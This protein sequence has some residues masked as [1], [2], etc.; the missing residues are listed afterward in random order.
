MSYCKTHQRKFDPSEG[1]ALC[2]EDAEMTGTTLDESAYCDGCAQHLAECVCLDPATV[3]AATP[4]ADEILVETFGPIL[5]K[6]T[7]AGLFPRHPDCKNHLSSEEPGCDWC[8]NQF[9]LDGMR[10]P[11]PVRAQCLQECIALTTGDRNKTYG[12]PEPNLTLQME[13]WTLYKRAAGDKHSMAHD[14]AMQH[15]FAKLAR[16]ASGP[17]LHKDNYL[18]L[19]NYSVIAYECDVE[20]LGVES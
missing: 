8:Q 9:E 14:A 16:I 13:L 18:D 5:E 2:A 19:S 10:D 6:Y 17:P 15:V 4:T 12:P 20:V 3:M 11:L 7:P 1:C